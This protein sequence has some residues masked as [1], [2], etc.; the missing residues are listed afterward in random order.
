MEHNQPPSLNGR[1]ADDG[2][3]AETADPVVLHP[4]RRTRS[5]RP[6]RT[7]F[8]VDCSIIKSRNVVTVDVAYII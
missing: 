8:T 3:A 1:V 2:V 7:F 6:R 5:S 4:G